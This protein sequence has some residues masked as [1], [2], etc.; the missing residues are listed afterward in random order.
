MNQLTG[1]TGN[2]ITL[3][4]LLIEPECNRGGSM[5]GELGAMEWALSEEKPRS[6]SARHRTCSTSKRGL[7]RGFLACMGSSVFGSI[8]PE[9]LDCL[10]GGDKEWRNI[11]LMLRPC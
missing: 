8:I 2:D 4:I 1:E 5:L 3:F 6:H 11:T 9:L 10:E 7:R